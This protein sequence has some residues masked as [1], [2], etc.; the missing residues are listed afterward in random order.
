MI[1]KFNNFDKVNEAL[2]SWED[3]I[4]KSLEGDIYYLPKGTLILKDRTKKERP[5]D[6]GMWLTTQNSM[7]MDDGYHGEEQMDVVSFRNYPADYT[8]RFDLLESEPQKE[9]K[10]RY[11]EFKKEQQ[12]AGLKNSKDNW[13]FGDE[14][15]QDRTNPKVKQKEEQIKWLDTLI[16]KQ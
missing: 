6:F 5:S 7:R 2:L 13:G 15:E 14:A 11:L 4:T 16:S 10:K 12:I 1:K 8:V 9:L 3:L